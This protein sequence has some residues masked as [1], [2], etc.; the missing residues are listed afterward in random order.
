MSLAE[1]TDTADRTNRSAEWIAYG[2]AIM[3]VAAA[4]LAAVVVDRVAAIPNLSLVFV[5]PVVIAAVRFGWGPAMAAALLGVLADNF[6]LIEPRYTLR[7]ADPANVWALVLLLIVAGVVS[8]LAAQSRRRAVQAWE[9]VDQSN[10]LHAMARALVAARD[11]GAIARLCADALARIFRAPA[12]IFIEQGDVLRP[13]ARAGG[14][15]ISAAD[16]EAARWVLASKLP[17]RGG[18][19]P[20]DGCDYDL[21]PV[22]TPLRGRAVIG[23]RLAGREDRPE[24][25]ER[26]VEIV[27]GYLAVALDREEYARQALESR[28]AVE[29]ERLKSD[30]LA[31]VSH[32][33]KT[34]LSTILVAL[35][36]LRR[37]G[38]AHDEKTRVELLA[39]A[40]AEA[41]RLTAMVAK[42]LDMNRLEAGAVV[43]RKA[44]AAPRELVAQALERATLALGGHKLA[45]GVKAR[46]APLMVDASLFETALANVLENAGKFSPPGSTIRIHAGEEDGSGWIEVTDEGPGFPS[47]VEPL[48]EKFN[49]GVTGDGR[50]PGAG[51][52]L[53]IARGFIE[54]QGGRI[55]AANRI[56]RPGA[57][58]RLIAP[59]ASREPAE[60]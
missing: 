60:A 33:L 6:F 50:P 28:V 27:G 17:T 53:T 39:A 30:L 4:T 40:E 26:I 51:L 21:W 36:S 58:V 52:G 35:Q 55:G 32:D 31:A 12:V 5:L 44:P 43:V 48:F 18:F 46:A 10:A 25:P 11:R 57:I 24:A 3:L 29:S 23:V 45:N 20:S 47:A 2:L 13:A 1:V 9:A 41:T 54:A 56:G 19:Y 42:L 22:Q 16:E 38:D 8:A 14:A 15:R 59:L 7:V 49:R 37:F 34:P